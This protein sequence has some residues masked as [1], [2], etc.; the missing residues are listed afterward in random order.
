[1]PGFEFDYEITARDY[2][3]GQVLLHKASGRM[4]YAPLWLLFGVASLA[5]ACNEQRVNWPSVLLAGLGVW[6]IYC[7]AINAFP[8]WFLRRSYRKTQ[9]AG[10]KYKAV[11]SDEGFAVTE[12]LRSWQSRWQGVSVK[13][14]DNY[15][16]AFF[17]GSTLFIFGKSYLGDSQQDEL[18]V[19]AGLA[20]RSSQNHKA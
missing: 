13:A 1:L 11:I 4:R 5:I 19:L 16:F 2:V 10:V 6:W 3:A 14:E 17:S 18:R 7:G 20:V 15:V 8:Q 9:L 12:P